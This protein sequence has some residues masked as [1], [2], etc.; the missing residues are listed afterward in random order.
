M[1]YTVSGAFSTGRGFFY[2]CPG[3]LMIDPAP[4]RGL[5]GRRGASPQLEIEIDPC[6]Y[7]EAVPEGAFPER[8][9]AFS[10]IGSMAVSVHMVGMGEPCENSGQFR[11][12]ACIK[13]GHEITYPL[14]TCGRVECPQCV[15]TWARRASERSGARVWGALHAGVTK[16]HPQ[17]VTFELSSLS[18]K[19]AKKKAAAIGLT[20]GVLVLHAH[21]IKKEWAQ[22]FEITAERCAANRYDIVRE[23]ALG[24]DA[25]EFSPHAH[26]IGFGRLVDIKKDSGNY[27][28]RNIRRLNSQSAVERTLSYILGHTV[29][30]PTE[31]ASV[32]RYFGI[33]SVQKLKPTWSG[34]CRA[35]LMCPCCGGA[36]VEKD[37]IEE[38]TVLRYIALGWHVVS[39]RRRVTG[40]TGPPVAPNPVWGTDLPAGLCI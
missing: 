17:H 16:H 21:R 15:K 25:L 28:Y 29:L 23:S 3:G 40:G 18:W 4:L 37:T 7:H 31:R 12:G 9:D 8:Y 24:L 34:R 20:G 5:G 6:V 33:C 38:L 32:V 10:Q 19:E 13:C 36:M 22:M 26:A 14:N 2:G 39:P 27:L 11:V 35:G 30:P 1:A